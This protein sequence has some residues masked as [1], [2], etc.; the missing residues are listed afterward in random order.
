VRGSAR[1]H[2][3]RVHL[4]IGGKYLEP[5]LGPSG[6]GRAHILAHCCTRTGGGDVDGVQL[7]RSSTKRRW[8]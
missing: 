5:K 7:V 1:V 8:S 3:S 2:A 4:G 6:R